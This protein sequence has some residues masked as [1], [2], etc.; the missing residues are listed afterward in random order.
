MRLATEGPRPPHRSQTRGEPLDVAE[1]E[2]WGPPTFRYGWCC[3]RPRRSSRQRT[4]R[5]RA[6]GR[7]PSRR[8]ARPRA[9]TYHA[10]QLAGAQNLHRLAPADGAGLGQRVRVDGATLREEGRDPVE[11]DDLEDDLVVVLEARELGQTHEQRRLTTLEPR[12]RV[13]AR[14][15]AL[16]TATGRLALGALT[17]TDTGLGGDGAG[18]RTQ[19]VNFQCH[20]E[21]FLRLPRRARGAAPSRP[22]RGSRDGPPARPSR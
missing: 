21:S 20:S 7:R 3:P 16:G 19:V 15:G 13:A 10:A 17:A 9:Q 2:G 18:G 8:P 4:R 6:R 22:S 11:V 12:G 1:G 5:R 14:A